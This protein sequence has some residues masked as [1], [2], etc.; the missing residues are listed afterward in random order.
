MDRAS[1]S[2]GDRR[3]RWAILFATLFVGLVK[4]AF[5]CAEEIAWQPWSEEVLAE[6]QTRGR[7]VFVSGFSKACPWCR[8]MEGG[9]FEDEGLQKLIAD[10]FLPVRVNL[11]ERDKVPPRFESLQPPATIVLAADGGELFAHHGYL[12]AH[13]L[14]DALKEVVTKRSPSRRSFSQQS[15]LPSFALGLNEAAF[16]LQLSKAR[17]GDQAAR[18]WL[19]RSLKELEERHDSVWGG[20]FDL[21]KR[22]SYIKSLPDQNLALWMFLVGSE[23]FDKPTY[24]QYARDTARY[25]MHFLKSDRGLFEQHTD[26]ISKDVTPADY[27]KLDD[28]HR[29]A[30]G[31]PKVSNTT[32]FSG[33]ALMMERMVELYGVTGETEYLNYAEVIRSSLSGDA[34]RRAKDPSAEDSVAMAQGLLAFYSV[35]A[36]RKFLAM[37]SQVLHNARRHY[38]SVSGSQ[39]SG[40]ALAQFAR[41]AI[42]LSRY[43][44]DAPLQREAEGVVDGLGASV[45]KGEG[46]PR[47]VEVLEEAR[48]EPLHIVV[49]GSKSNAQARAL[50][51]EAIRLVH[52]YL[53]REW[54]DR[55]EG[56]LPNPDVSYPLLPRPAAFLCFE[57]RCSLPLFTES[58]LRAK[59]REVVPPL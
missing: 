55:E 19:E 23:V 6:A 36:D 40:A 25:V 49:V 54:W 31:I 11:R 10:S 38:R 51:R 20:V 12:E 4:P 3:L 45:S 57:K 50:W 5:V 43:L 46:D 30:M 35:T 59:L 48:R 15:T 39:A 58:E 41:V 26:S 29:R 33:S 9:A 37:S 18:A 32:S 21:S 24:E 53:R 27:F 14:I 56:P 1:A 22:G 8:K 34:R 47:I 44:G 28:E 16:N 17:Q 2:M 52:P 7:L 42:T 13:E